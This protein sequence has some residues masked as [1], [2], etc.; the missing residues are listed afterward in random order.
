MRG[1]N[2]TQSVIRL[3]KTLLFVLF[4][5]N[6]QIE[7]SK[8]IKANISIHGEIVFES[9]ASTN[10]YLEINPANKGIPTIDKAPIE[11][12]IPLIISIRPHPLIFLNFLESL[13]TYDKC[14]LEI[15]SKG[16]VIACVKI[17]KIAAIKAASSPIPI[18]INM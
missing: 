5:T 14:S 9:E 11:K 13:D 16:L 6:K 8:A 4:G 2:G 12:Q 15:N 1:Q 18:P 17:W 3:R 7:A 10:K